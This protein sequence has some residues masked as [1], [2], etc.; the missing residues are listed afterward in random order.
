M[1]YTINNNKVSQYFDLPRLNQIDKDQRFLDEIALHPATVEMVNPQYIFGIEVEAENV[2]ISRLAATH[3]KLW[4]II[5]DNSLR[6]NGL[7]FVSLPLKS[8]YIEA[9]LT[10]LN[11]S[12]NKDVVF[13]PRTSVHVH[14]NVRD[15][16]MSQITNVVLIYTAVEDLLFDWIGHDRDKNIFCIK[17]T[18]TNYVHSF[19]TLQRDPNYAIQFWNKYTALNL[20]PMSCKGTVEFRHMNGTSDTKHILTWINLLSCIKNLAK[21]YTTEAIINTLMS[22][23]TCSFYEEFIIDLF[24]DYSKLFLNNTPIQKRMENA[25]SYI[26]LTQSAEQPAPQRDIA[27]TLRERPILGRIPTRAEMTATI[28]EWIEPAPLIVGFGDDIM[29]APVPPIPPTP[30]ERAV[31]LGDRG[32]FTPF[33]GRLIQDRPAPAQID[34]TTGLNVT[35]NT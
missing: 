33:T 7:E 11:N 24:G 25:I 30:Q 14:M 19:L 8:K 27:T 12:L 31:N 15:L 6:N 13:S 10:Q 34:W 3:Q 16:T 32:T 5:T 1:D 22:L 29:D 26:K 2:Q 9:A 17:L 35:A 4:S 21:R 23:N 18:E 28:D 20:A